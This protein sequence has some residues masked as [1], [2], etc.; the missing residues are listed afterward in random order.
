MKLEEL[1]RL[2]E[3]KFLAHKKKKRAYYLKKKEVKKVY[4][5][6]EELNNENFSLKIKEII[7]A[8][9][10]YLDNRK[11]IIISKLNDYK[12]KKKE[13]YELNKEKRLE[14]DKEYREKRKE[15]LKE[16]RKEYYKK[17]KENKSIKE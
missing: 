3:E 5:Y 1:K 2:R 4:D 16:Y 8:Q 9:K 11:D 6:E 7:K 15:E 14:Y 13:Y 12:N 10:N 17:L